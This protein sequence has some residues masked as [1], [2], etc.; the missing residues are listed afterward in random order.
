MLFSKTGKVLVV[1]PQLV[2][3]TVQT[4]CVVLPATEVTSEKTEVFDC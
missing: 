2:S 3:V 4:G 1:F